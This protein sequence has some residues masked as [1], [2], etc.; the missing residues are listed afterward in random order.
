[1]ITA[2]KRYKGAMTDSIRHA[3]VSKRN[4]TNLG[5]VL[6]IARVQRDRLQ[7]ETAVKVD[8]RDDV[9]KRG[10][11]ALDGSN[12]LLLE[13]ERRRSSGDRRRR[14]RGRTSNGRGVSTTSHG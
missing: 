2:A 1:M 8:C 5:V 9:L 12:V 14:R 11:D 3:T 10:H 6:G 7:I 4:C 13:R